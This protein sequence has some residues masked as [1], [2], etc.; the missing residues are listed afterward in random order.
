MNDL[1]TYKTNISK[2][3]PLLQSITKDGNASR[4]IV[5]SFIEFTK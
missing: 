5:V 1:S 2:L 4:L 3:F